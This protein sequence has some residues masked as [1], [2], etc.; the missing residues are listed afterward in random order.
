MGSYEFEEWKKSYGNDT[1]EDHR[2][3]YL[4]EQD[5]GTAPQGSVK[6]KN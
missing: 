3:L 2:R 1:N 4:G 5:S 6:V